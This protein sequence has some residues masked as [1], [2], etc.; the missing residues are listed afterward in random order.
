MA[1]S[2]NAMPAVAVIPRT[3]ESRDRYRRSGR[4]TVQ[5]R[6]DRC[7]ATKIRRNRNSAIHRTAIHD[8]RPRAET[9]RSGRRS[10]RTRW[11]FRPPGR[12]RWCYRSGAPIVVRWPKPGLLRMS[13]STRRLSS[14]RCACWSSPRAAA[15]TPVRGDAAPR[16]SGLRLRPHLDGRRHDYALGFIPRVY[17][18]PVRVPAPGDVVTRFP[19]IGKPKKQTGKAHAKRYGQVFQRRQ[20][21]W[22]HHA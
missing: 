2:A 15:T 11:L 8:A 21:F 6:R 5:A 12:I 19:T 18:P 3:L 9:P 7:R 13:P 1:G 20:G 22:F 4:V 10:S 17:R 14:R 16:R